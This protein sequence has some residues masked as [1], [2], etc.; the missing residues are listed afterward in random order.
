MVCTDPWGGKDESLGLLLHSEKWYNPA[1]YLFSF[2]TRSYPSVFV[3]LYFL[4]VLFCEELEPYS[5]STY[6]VCPTKDLNKVSKIRSFRFLLTLYNYTQWHSEQLL[7]H[8]KVGII[9]V[10]NKKK[11]TLLLATINFLLWVTNMWFLKKM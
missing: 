4:I 10:A 11:Q 6:P 3:S 7:K 1:N 5:Q 2:S 8:C 9:W